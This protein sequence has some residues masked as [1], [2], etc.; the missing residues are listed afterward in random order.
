MI[1]WLEVQRAHWKK[2]GQGPKLAELAVP[3]EEK[4]LLQEELEV[5]AAVEFEELKMARVAEVRMRVVEVVVLR[6]VQVPKLLEEA[7]EEVGAQMELV[8][9]MP[10]AE[11]EEGG[12]LLELGQ[13]KLGPAEGEP[14]AA[15]PWMKACEMLGAAA[16]SFQSAA[17]VP[18]SS[19]RL[20]RQ[21]EVWEVLVQEFQE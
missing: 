11:E 5:V 4:E 7:A 16:A 14:E 9:R 18:W 12:Q 1:L 19:S 13:L 2:A 21:E 8:L 3:E 6:A 17:V 10:A 20:G 15:W